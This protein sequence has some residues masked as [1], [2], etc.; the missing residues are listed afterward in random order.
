LSASYGVARISTLLVT[1]H[2]VSNPAPL[3][4]FSNFLLDV[5]AGMASQAV[6]D[7]LNRI[8]QGVLQ[9]SAGLAA[10]AAL[11]R[12]ASQ[13]SLSRSSINSSSVVCINP[14]N[15]GTYLKHLHQVPRF[16][17]ELLPLSGSEVGSL[18]GPAEVRATASKKGGKKGEPD[19]WTAESIQAEVNRALEEVLGTR[20]A[21]DE[22][23]M[24]GKRRVS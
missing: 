22:P 19:D 7:R 6:K 17:E 9:V 14:F 11:L 3:P 13:S 2:V 5:F 10:L 1:C 12:G 8:G 16:Y 15:W 23:L 4:Y 18:E 21:A 24:S 20:L